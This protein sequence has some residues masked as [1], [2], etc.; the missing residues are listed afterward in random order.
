MGKKPVRHIVYSDDDVPLFNK[1]TIVNVLLIPAITAIFLGGGVF[2]AGK[3]LL[4]QNTA[5]IA[6][7]TQKRETAIAEETKRRE[8]AFAAMREK[9]DV[10]Q[11]AEDAKREELRQALLTNARETSDGIAKLTAHALVQDEQIKNV[12]EQIKNQVSSI[13]RVVTGLQNLEIAVGHVTGGKR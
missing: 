13:D 8:E 9:R 7:E 5:A 4:D 11:K 3:L 1:G 2:Y 10:S 12:G 6:I